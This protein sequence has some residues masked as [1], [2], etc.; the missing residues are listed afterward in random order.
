MDQEFFRTIAWAGGQWMD[1]FKPLGSP[2]KDPDSEEEEPLPEGL[3]SRALAS[4]R[5][6]EIAG[7][8][9]IALDRDLNG[10][11][12]FSE[13]L[14]LRRSVIAWSQCTQASMNRAGLRCGLN[15][16]VP[17]KN[18][19]QPEAD[20]LYSLGI[21]FNEIH[22][23]KMSFCAFIYLVDIYKV[24]SKFN[25]PM[26]TGVVNQKDLVR[27]IEELDF[28]T[29]ITADGAKTIFNAIGQ[30]ELQIDQFGWALII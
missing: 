6:H 19:S 23:N 13:Y 11:L 28:P 14:N 2:E 7:D 30:D 3:D 18:L 16:A 25:E 17:G 5:A 4:L 9:L 26:D 20:V 1:T 21:R 24:F 10:V 8:L 15:I 27:R 12:N 22:D 29:R